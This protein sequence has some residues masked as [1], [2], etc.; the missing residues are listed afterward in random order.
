MRDHPGTSRRTGGR[1]CEWIGA[2]AGTLNRA[3]SRGCIHAD[4]QHADFARYT[5]QHPAAAGAGI[6]CDWVGFN[7]LATVARCADPRL[8]DS[9]GA[10]RG[11]GMILMRL[12]ERI[13]IPSSP[14]LRDS[15]AG[16]HQRD[17]GLEGPD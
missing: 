2:G 1:S 5:F 8:K 15:K 13:S 17:S 3:S 16:G 12:I 4:G 11:S 10:D 9:D 6:C 7:S 14:K